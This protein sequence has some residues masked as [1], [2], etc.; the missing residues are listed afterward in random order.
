M[1]DLNAMTKVVSTWQTEQFNANMLERALALAEE[2]GEVARVVLKTSNNVR[3][4][5][6]GNLREELADV[7]LTVCGLAGAGDID[8]E[9]AVRE[10]FERLLS[11]DFRA[12]PEAGHR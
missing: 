10:K 3:P 7:F 12:D 5:T 4:S 6:R 9:D 1:I 8:L 2:A 11:L